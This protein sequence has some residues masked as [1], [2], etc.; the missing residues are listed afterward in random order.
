[1]IDVGKTKVTVKCM[2]KTGLT[3][4]KWPQHEDI[5]DYPIVDIITVI[6]PPTPC[7]ARRQCSVPEVDKYW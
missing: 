4:W 5:H 3:T 6:K 7:G 1:V 2:R